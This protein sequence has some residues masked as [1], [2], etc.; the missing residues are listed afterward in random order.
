MSRSRSGRVLLVACLI[1]AVARG[2]APA[3]AAPTFSEAL[4]AGGSVPVGLAPIES[5][6]EM[7]GRHIAFEVT[8]RLFMGTNDTDVFVHDV[9]T[10]ALTNVSDRSGD[11]DLDDTNPDVSMDTVVYQGILNLHVNVYLYNTTWYNWRAVTNETAAQTMPRISGHYVLWHD[12]GTTALKYY[13]IDWPQYMN[14][15]IPGTVGVYYGSWDIDGDTVVYAREQAAGDFTF[16]KWTLWSDATPEAF[17]THIGAGDIADVRLH[18]GRMTY[19][20]GA[21][22]DNVGVTMLHDGDA[23]PLA[24]GGRDADLFHEMYAYELIAND[25]IGFLHNEVWSTVLGLPANIETDPSV[26]GNRVAYV[27]DSYGGDIYMTRSSERL[28]DRTAG[29]DR[30]ATSAAVSQEYFRGGADTVVMCTGEDFPDAL[31]AAPWARFLKAPVLLTKRT[32][33]PQSVMDEIT[34]LGAMNVWI[35]GGDG[36]VAPSVQTQLE[37]AGLSVDRQLQ[38]ADRYATSAKIANFLYDALIA[39]G[40]PFSNTAFVANGES[41]AGALAVDR[42]WRPPTRR[43]C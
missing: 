38:G 20:Y 34:R 6:P 41:F 32:L 40:R 2:A 14:Q 22:L 43:S 15:Q 39:D 35:I 9:S 21:A 24:F 23:G 29:A 19:T 18:N 11:N 42:L 33:V 4:V 26:F 8:P 1:S 31:A 13:F 37:A 36:A 16:Y 25:N 3:A 10:G 12:A 5:N 27:R 28:L 7:D 17:A 30:Y